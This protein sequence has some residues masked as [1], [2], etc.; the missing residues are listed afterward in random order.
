MSSVLTHTHAHTFLVLHRSQVNPQF[1]VRSAIRNLLR[2]FVI[3]QKFNHKYAVKHRFG[4]AQRAQ[5]I[6]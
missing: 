2:M 1:P 3:R 4:E 5:W 6:I